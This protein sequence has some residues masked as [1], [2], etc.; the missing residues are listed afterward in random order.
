MSA[1]ALT[2]ID[3]L[4]DPTLFKPWFEGK[5]WNAWR[6]SKSGAVRHCSVVGFSAS[7]AKFDLRYR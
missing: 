1:P 7:K 4:D 6:T 2:I 3:T 5:S